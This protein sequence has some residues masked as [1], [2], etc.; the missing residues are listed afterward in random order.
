[1][2]KIQR[3]EDL[4]AWQKAHE[5]VLGV[6]RVTRELPKEEMFCLTSQV[7]RA[8][9]STPSNIVEGFSRWSNADKARH[10]NIAEA[11][12]EEARYQLL[13]AQDL[14][15]AD[16]AALRESAL[17]AKR[18]LIGLSQSVRPCT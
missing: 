9:I 17:E 8:A 6:Y 5:F 18:V 13:L 4:T 15:Y 3:F 2:S 11:S 10:Y 1:M 7:R 16:T 14:G 12:L